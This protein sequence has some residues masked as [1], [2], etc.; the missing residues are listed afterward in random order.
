MFEV[1]VKG[2]GRVYNGIDK[3]SAEQAFVSAVRQSISKINTVDDLHVTIE[4]DGVV[5]R[6]YEHE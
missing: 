6:R 2:V 4:R 3:H 1:F 5:I